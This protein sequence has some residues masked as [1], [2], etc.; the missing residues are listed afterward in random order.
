MQIRGRR[1]RM[2]TK[3]FGDVTIVRLESKE[4][5][6]RWAKEQKEFYYDYFKSGWD[7]PGWYVPYKVSERCP[8]GCCRESNLYV[9]HVD[10][11]LSDQQELIEAV[12]K[13]D[14]VAEKD[15]VIRDV[16]DS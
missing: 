16:H 4:E 3:Q 1:S 2:E 8:R 7:G 15:R 10:S 14:K 12:Q 5:A 13:I 6:Q 11:W 9:D